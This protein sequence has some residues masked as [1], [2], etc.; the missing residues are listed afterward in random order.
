MKHN[1][2]V[3]LLG[4]RGSIPVS[5]ANFLKYGGS[6]LCVLVQMGG[7]TILLDCGTGMLQVGHLTR[8]VNHLSILLSHPHIDHL[9]GLP[10]CPFLYEDGK[11]VTFHAVARGG[12]SAG[13]QVKTLMSPPL[14]PV[15]S[16]VF[17]AEITFKDILEPSIR[18]GSVS[19]EQ[20]ELFHPGGA[21]AFRLTYCGRSLVYASDCELSDSLM[22]RL[23][24]FA[25]GCDLLL[26]D[27]QYSDEE[28]PRRVGWGHSSWSMAAALGKAS[29]AKRTVLIHHA[30]EYTDEYLDK[31]DG[32]LRLCHPNCTL[33]RC[34]EEFTL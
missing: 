9:I 21:S 3:V 32:W 17:K 12:L 7:E 19:V 22:A 31:A 4:V 20:F 30:P 34:G 10:L 26:C 8:D 29:G 6:T 1:F 2:R 18:I 33:G 11:Q 25:K 23:S 5:G 28:Y 14:W 24:T 13:Q 16:E 27:G 15:G